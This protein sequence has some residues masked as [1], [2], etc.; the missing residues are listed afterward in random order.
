MIGGIVRNLIKT[1]FPI[2]REHLKFHYR[3]PASENEI[4][5][6]KKSL[7]LTLIP[8]ELET[9][10]L[11]HNGIDEMLDEMIIGSLVWDIERTVETNLSMRNNLIYKDMYKSFENFLFF[12]DAGNGD[13][14]A[15]DIYKNSEEIYV[16][17]H[18][19]DSRNLIAPNLFYFLPNWIN[20]KITI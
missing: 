1:N 12:A 9:L 19:D 8:K 4:T 3:Q 17:D 13:L 20:G 15:Y 16:W 10:L 5:I 6:F 14:F 11:E 2:D 18:E 7:E